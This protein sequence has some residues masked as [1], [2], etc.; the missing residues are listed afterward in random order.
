MVNEMI[1]IFLSR[2]IVRICLERGNDGLGFTIVGGYGSPPGDLPIFVKTVYNTGAASVDGRL[3][4]GDQLVAVNGQSLQGVTHDEAVT[5][6]KNA[7]GL[8][9]LAILK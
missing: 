9:E 7:K 8:I 4:T 6:L 2:D 5:L 1:F 3:R